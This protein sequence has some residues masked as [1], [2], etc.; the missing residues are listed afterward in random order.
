ME[1]VSS[2][3]TKVRLHPRSRNPASQTKLTRQLLWLKRPSSNLAVRLGAVSRKV[4][5][6]YSS[7][8]NRLAQA[9]V[10]RMT[11]MVKMR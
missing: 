9:E 3:S 11:V 6:M 8:M 7:Q 1:S 2:I 10:M 5:A 4:D